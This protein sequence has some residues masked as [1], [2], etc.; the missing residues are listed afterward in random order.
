[1][2]SS[3]LDIEVIIS[4]YLLVLLAAL[5][6]HLVHLFEIFTFHKFRLKIL[7]KDINIQL[8]TFA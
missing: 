4:R 5:H 7:Y 6:E 8:L 3:W 2:K 1:M